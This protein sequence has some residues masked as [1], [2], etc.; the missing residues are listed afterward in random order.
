MQE[1]MGTRPFNMKKGTNYNAA[2]NFTDQTITGLLA[3]LTTPTKIMLPW[4][5]IGSRKH[6]I[7][8]LMFTEETVM[9]I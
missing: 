4:M 2:V 3:E 9:T 8:Y 1:E 7:T 6:M 5:H